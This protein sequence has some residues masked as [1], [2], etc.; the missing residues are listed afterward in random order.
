MSAPTHK[1]VVFVPYSDEEL[2]AHKEQVKKE[3]QGTGSYCLTELQNELKYVQENGHIF[4]NPP[5]EVATLKALI[6]EEESANEQQS[7]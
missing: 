4:R 1:H 6:A 2:S 3:M 7:T 5:L